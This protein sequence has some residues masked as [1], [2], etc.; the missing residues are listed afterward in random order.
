MGMMIQNVK[1]LELNINTATF[2]FNTKTLKM[3]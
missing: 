2:F 1:F 3:I